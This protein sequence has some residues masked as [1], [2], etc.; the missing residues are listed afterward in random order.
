MREYT[1][2]TASAASKWKR[3]VVGGRTKSGKTHF[4][5][6][7]PK[8]WFLS[9]ATEGG[10]ATLRYMDKEMWW[11]KTV[12]PKVSEIENMMEFPQFVTK[13]VNQKVIHE[14][15]LV[16]DSLSIYAAR[17][18]REL[19]AA[20]PGQDNRQRYGELADVM[21]LQLGRVHSLPMHIVWLCHINDEMQL[22][23]PGKASEALWAYMDYLWMTRVET[24]PGRPTDFQLHIRPFL[25]ATWL[26]GRSAIAAP[27][28]IIPSFKVLVELLDLLDRPVSL[29][30]PDFGG[31]SYPN[32]A[33]YKI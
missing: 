7:W 9:D 3:V 26:G 32:G 16:I 15:T 14:Q 28:P 33:S 6:T 27:S 20:N 19:R 10:A 11:D 8:P 18:L 30:V 24:Q 2:G 12:P 5:S 1:I 29:A 4:A 25:R 17:V 13:L 22:T 23:V 21:S 31:Q